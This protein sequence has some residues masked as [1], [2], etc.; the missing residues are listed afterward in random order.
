LIDPSV[1]YNVYCIVND[2]TNQGKYR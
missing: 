2:K 1:F